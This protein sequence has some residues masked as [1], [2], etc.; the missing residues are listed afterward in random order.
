MIKTTQNKN[1]HV[2][3][4]TIP[5][6][7]RLSPAWMFPQPEFYNR[8]FAKQTK[9]AIRDAALCIEEGRLNQ[10][11]HLIDNALEKDPL[12]AILHYLKAQSLESLG[13]HRKAE[14]AYS[15]EGQI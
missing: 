12:P 2:L 5:F 10:A 4:L 11:I 6:N 14:K 3:L 15:L 1:V 9:V 8:N 13:D 7:Y